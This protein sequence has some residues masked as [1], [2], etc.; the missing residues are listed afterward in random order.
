M[1]HLGNVSTLNEHSCLSQV[2][3]KASFPVVGSERPWKGRK[4][5]P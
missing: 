2:A 5:K 1:R 4:K 3:T